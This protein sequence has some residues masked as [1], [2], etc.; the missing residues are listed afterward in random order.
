MQVHPARSRLSA[1]QPVLAF[2]FMIRTK[3]GDSST[4][5]S[6]RGKPLTII[7]AMSLFSGMMMAAGTVVSAPPAEAVHATGG[8]GDYRESIDWFEWG[9]DNSAIP[10]GGMT[11]TNSR[12]IAGKELATTCHLSDIQGE[13]RTYTPGRWRG[14]G[15]DD[16]YNIG[17]TDQDNQLV[18]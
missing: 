11:R 6:R 16:L 12:I 4:P 17:G 2:L 5:R 1:L 13:I 15:L 18:I 3:H 14:D 8:D 7:A 10:A 9:A